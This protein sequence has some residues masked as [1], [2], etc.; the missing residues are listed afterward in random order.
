M[1]P[2]HLKLR[3]FMSYREEAQLD[4]ARLRVACLAGDNGAGKSALL[5]AIT[6]AL[7]GKARTSNDRELVALGESEMEVTFCFRLRERDYRIFR[8][9]AFGHKMTHALELAVRAVGDED[10]TS[11]SGDNVRQ[12]EQK[13]VETLNLDYDTFVNSAFILQG[14]ADSFTEKPPRD[15]KKVL[16]D[17]LNLGEYDELAVLARDQERDL[18]GQIAHARQRIEVLEGRL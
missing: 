4:F 10:W 7:W 6:W 8:R 14:K 13:I 11:I 15:R 2:L 12:T 18:K 17:I 5:D 3:N 9:R 1:T 16:S